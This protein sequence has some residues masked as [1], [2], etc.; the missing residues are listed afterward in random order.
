MTVHTDLKSPALSETR[1]T[2]P[3]VLLRA[4]EI[5]MEQFRPMLSAHGMT[6]QQWRV[7]RVLRERGPTDATQLAKGAAILGPSLSRILKALEARGFITSHRDPSDGRRWII[8]LTDHGDAFIAKL[9]PEAQEI[10]ARIE[11]KLSDDRID[12]LLDELDRLL[13]LLAE[14]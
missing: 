10:Y 2:L 14:D 4:R 1:R 6:D 7:L 9:T 13:T 5:V 11:A 12:H 3:I 8:S